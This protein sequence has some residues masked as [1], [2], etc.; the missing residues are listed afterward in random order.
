[1][2]TRKIHV[3]STLGFLIISGGILGGC[4]REAQE[5][6]PPPVAGSGQ[7]P[8]EALAAKQ[9]A[10]AVNKARAEAQGKAMQQNQPSAPK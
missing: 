5:N 9:R 2:K 1:M 3:M 10:D 7:M 4:S 6:S 8:P